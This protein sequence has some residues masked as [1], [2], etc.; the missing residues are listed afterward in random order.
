MEMARLCIDYFGDGVFLDK[1][2]FWPVLNAVDNLSLN[3][4]FY[5]LRGSLVIPRFMFP[6]KTNAPVPGAPLPFD[7]Y[8]F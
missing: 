5:L 2:L 3:L 1:F 7:R 4:K 6:R 8:S